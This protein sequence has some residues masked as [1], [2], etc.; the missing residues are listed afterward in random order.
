[1][2]FRHDVEEVQEAPK[3]NLELKIFLLEV[4]PELLQE[5][6]KSGDYTP[7]EIMQLKAA[8]KKNKK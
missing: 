8:S 2:F 7:Y 5:V 3:K 1:M 4:Y 6:L